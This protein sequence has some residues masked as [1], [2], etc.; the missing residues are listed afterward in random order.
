MNRI[1]LVFVLSLVFKTE[2]QTSVL[3]VADS[4]YAHGNYSKAIESYNTLKNKDQV[5]H[6]IAMSYAA[7]GN[8][9]EALKNYEAYITANPN[10]ALIIYDY[11]KLLSN[12]K[13]HKEAAAV[14]NNLIAID[15]KNP[16]YYYQLGMAL[17]E[18]KDSTALNQFQ[19]T[20]ELDNTHQKAIYRIAK[21]NLI[22]REYDSVNHYT[23]I[24]LKSYAD[25]KELISLKAQNYYSKKDYRQAIVWYEK[26]IELGESSP[27]IHEQ[28]STSYHWIYDFEKAIEQRKLVLEFNPN[29]A[30]TIYVIGTY[31]EE[32]NDLV[33]AE[34]YITKALWLMD[35]PLND[36]Y[37]RLG[38]I[39]NRQKKYKE[40]IEVLKK[41]VKEDPTNE[42]SNF[43][44]ALTYNEYYADYDAKIRAF[45]NFKE[46][47][48]NGKLR[49]FVD[50]RISELKKEKFMKDGQ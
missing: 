23:D 14:F 8:Y 3:N 49:E 42:F 6:K 11:A 44:L 1:F 43:Q 41:S 12:I 50:S 25:N 32:L 34:E 9:T 36:E 2:A 28:L 21:F 37:R 22:K 13:K 31:Y 24:G 10:D 16:N 40:A 35:E 19:K 20:F 7:I 29:D 4:L 48:P 46:K 15:A 33:N 27:F 5:F 47:F 38:T 26:L 18:L 45:E 17:E 30:T 39:L